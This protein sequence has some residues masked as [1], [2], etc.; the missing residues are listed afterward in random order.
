[1]EKINARTLLLI[2]VCYMILWR[3]PHAHAQGQGHIRCQNTIGRSCGDSSRPR[4]MNCCDYGYC[5]P[6][7]SGYYQCVDYPRGCPIQKTDTDMYGNDM[8]IISGLQPWECCDKCGSTLGCM[9]YT[10]INQDTDGSSKCYLKNAV[11]VG[12]EKKGVV[13]G[14][15]S[16]PVCTKEPGST[17]GSSNGY[18][19]CTNGNYCQPWNSGFYQCLS[20]PEQCPTQE[21][22]MDYYG[23]D[24]ETIYGLQ[25]DECCTKCTKTNGCVAYTFINE[26][27][28][29]KTACHLKSDFADRRPKV[30]AVSGRVK[31][32]SNSTLIICP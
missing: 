9:A 22:D 31:S 17:C 16:Y 2:G 19:C 12:T 3:I 8:A 24:I 20:V 28:D 13:S 6:W 26:N 15:L 21:T 11:A 7:N 14:V 1:M 25:P 5:Q 32:Q 10:F 27:P 23:F 29:G 4:E 30:G 18:S